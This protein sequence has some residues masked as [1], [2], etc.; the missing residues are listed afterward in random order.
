MSMADAE[1]SLLS[2]GRGVP[3]AVVALESS[4]RFSFPPA[5]L[6]WARL[7]SLPAFAPRRSGCGVPT[8][9][10]RPTFVAILAE[11]AF[12]GACLVVTVVFFLSG[13]S[14]VG[15]STSCE[16]SMREAETHSSRRLLN[17]T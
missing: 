5:L 10:P 12:E 2:C 17:S 8:L 7:R 14:G 1:S 6:G 3:V 15:H 4:S 9:E 16:R 13:F 11:A